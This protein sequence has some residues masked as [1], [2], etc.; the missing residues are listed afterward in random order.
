M[1]TKTYLVWLA[2]GALTLLSCHGGASHAEDVETPTDVEDYQQVDSL[3]E[4]AQ[5]EE[6]MLKEESDPRL[7][8]V[9]DDF[10]FAFLHNPRFR[11]N[12]IAKPLRLE[13][14]SRPTETL[15]SFDSDFEFAFLSG[16]FLTSLYGSNAEMQDADDGILADDTL[17]SVQRI[18]LNDG[19]VRHFKFRRKE[20]HWQL[21]TIREGSFDE[22]GELND[23]LRFY[24]K[25]CKD[26][27]TQTQYIS[28]PLRIAIQDPD[29]D[30]G[31]IDGTI[32]AN[33]WHSF[34]P[35]VPSGIISNI[36]REGQRYNSRKMILRK[37]GLSNGMQEVFTFTR[38]RDNWRLNRY[39]N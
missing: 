24:A 21:F 20:G 12:R 32:D 1:S 7:D 22:D 33:Q 34:C 15:D 18:N 23:F 37:S 16:D 6:S 3:E 14:P 27:T 17:I 31:C 9:F 29:D 19:T 38:E 39:E 25:F 35:E 8:A 13:H 5:E 30:E 10:L 36:Q 26:S 28:N 2:V 4:D 11:K